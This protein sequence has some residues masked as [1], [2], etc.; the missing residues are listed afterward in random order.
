M[1]KQNLGRSIGLRIIL[2]LGGALLAFIP[3]GFCQI[4]PDDTLGTER[5]AVTSNILIKGELGDLIEGGALRDANLFHSF[6]EFNVNSGQRVYFFNPNGVSNIL[7]RVTGNT[8]SNILGKLGVDGS[9]NLF[10]INPNGIIFGANARLDIQGSFTAS[11]AS[12]LTFPNGEQFSA[13]DPQAPPVLTINV[14][15]GL[16]YGPQ[17]GQIVNAGLLEV[18]QDLSL[19]GSSVIS[20]GQMLAPN[21]DIQL[22]GISG[23]VEVKHLNARTATLTATQNL[24]LLESQLTTT[25]DLNLLAQNS[26]IA[27]DSVMNPLIVQAGGHLLLQGDRSIDLFALN[28]PN[29]GLVSAGNMTLRSANTVIG[30][31]HYW[32]GGNFQIEQLDG[33]LGSLSSPNDPI[34]FA[35]GD[36]GFL[37]YQGTSLHILAGGRV[38]I[39]RY[40]WIRG[41]DT[42]ATTINPIARPGLANLTL[43]DGSQLVVNGN[44]QPTVDIRAGIDWTQQ[45]GLPG[46][47][48]VGISGSPSFGASATSADIRVGTIF[49][50]NA[51]LT[52][53]IRG[54][55]LLTNQYKPNI[56]LSGSIQ[57]DATVLG[58]YFTGREA[59]LTGDPD[60]GG[61]VIIDS[62]N[63]ILLN[64]LVDA[65]ALSLAGNGGNIKLL[66]NGNID[67]R[68]TVRSNGLRGG[69]IG[70]TS[71]GN[72]TSNA[73]I[74]S[75]G[76]LGG[77]INL[78]SKAAISF[79]GNQVGSFSNTLG[80]GA[81]GNINVQ[82]KS[83]SLTDGAAI[84]SLTYG[85]ANSGNLT[86]QADS[87]DVIGVAT[88]AIGTVTG[89]SGFK[90]QTEGTGNAGILQINT[91][92]LR[93]SNGARISTVST[94]QGDAG[95]LKIHATDLVE[96]VGTATDRDFQSGLRSDQ[97][98]Q[99]ASGN[100]GNLTI[101]TNK[102]VVKDGAQLGSGTYGMGD[103]GDLLVQASESV[104]VI[105]PSTSLST[106]TNS[107]GDAGNL[108]IET[109]RLN[110]SDGGYISSSTNG[111]GN[112]GN[113]AVQATS[114]EMGGN[115]EGKTSKLSSGV[116]Q[117]GTGNGGNLTISTEQL[118]VWD[119]AQIG[120]GSLG[121]GNAGSLVVDARS[122]ELDGGSTD[123]QSFSGL[124]TQTEQAGAG[125]DLLINTDRLTIR[126]GARVSATTLNSGQ[127]GDITVNASEFIELSGNS[128]FGDL[129]LLTAQTQGSGNAGNLRI[130]TSRLTIRDGGTVSAFT[131]S[132]GQAGT[133]TATASNRIEVIGT[134]VNGLPSSLNLSTTSSGDAGELRVVTNQ[135]MLRDGGRVSAFTRGSGQGGIIVVDASDTVD[136]A[137]TSPNGQFA[138][139][140]F[141]D[142]RSAGNARGIRVDTNQLTVYDRGQITVSGSGLGRA[143]DVEVNA[144]SVLVDSQGEITATTNSSL[145]GNVR[146]QGLTSLVMNNGSRISTSTVDGQGGI[147]DVSAR[148]VVRIGSGSQLASEATGSGL[149]GGVRVA[150]RALNVQDGAQM[151]VSNT[152]S[153]NAGNLEIA[154]NSVLLSN[155]GRLTAETRSGSGGNIQFQ[156]LMSLTL[157]DGS[158]ISTSTIDGLGGT[159]DIVARQA[160]VLNR[161]S[162]LSAESLGTGVAGTIRVDAQTIAMTDQTR[163]TGRT[164]SGE[165][166]NIQ[167]N[168]KESMTLRRDS[169]IRT[170]AFGSGNGGNISLQ[171]GTFILGILAEDSDVIASAVTGKGGKIYAKAIGIFGFRLFDGQ[172]TPDSDF[173]ASSEFGIDG[174]VTINAQNPQTL[175]PLPAEPGVPQI[176]LGCQALNQQQGI[177]RFF[178]SGRGGL[179][180]NPNQILSSSSV[181]EDTQASTSISTPPSLAT[182]TQSATAIIEA[183]GWVKHPDGSIVLVVEPTPA[184]SYI[185]VTLSAD[186][187]AR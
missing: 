127:A 110:I 33:N 58:G 35:N 158:E 19:S 112:A 179:P 184:S 164:A 186:C 169:D 122:I 68:S 140:L 178:N 64:G 85:G 129:S 84:I 121:N 155:S 180:P 80:F 38:F 108:K 2:G 185:P 74:L 130:N 39:P 167:L 113:L 72:I 12:Q 172:E 93:I 22:A 133:L 145:G 65:S 111:S 150:T 48:T 62:R 63:N 157:N 77:N 81:G 163:I 132:T 53:P 86:V 89:V 143:G 49:F 134:S 83:I 141:F 71:G 59:I 44:A 41:A 120:A 149:A 101:A 73:N 153:G 177:S 78:S 42:V 124:Y 109:R 37:F 182:D 114:I 176:A 66:A 46:N 138:S 152:G 14:P 20:T 183:Q 11:T 45:G 162:R 55:V 31:A 123:N 173:V 21:G 175:P 117:A 137:G 79:T 107:G 43:S 34:I 6:R 57:V 16:Q 118:T 25:G 40:I 128:A 13:I 91:N 94:D 98:T 15:I 56:S 8:P 151:S 76:L 181:W 174:T 126:N 104:E 67:Y 47:T 154:A 7:T 148:D 32:S 4:T 96:I 105:G 156:G 136:I 103:G 50:D 142:S 26:L 147:M 135:L 171:A 161:G 29:S 92:S 95:N 166:G 75:L 125:G 131:T 70:L 146:L 90:T 170:Q 106:S 165:G 36:V 30:D 139:G 60:G 61:S 9:A 88:D 168:A 24:N 51:T 159:I 116:Q 87:I 5:S 97:V 1:N 17:A 160:V 28:H 27:R 102:L 187:Y 54:Q 23:D 119:G 115:S 69:D 99:G 52:S 82:A 3:P 144:R 10:L 100:A 18:G